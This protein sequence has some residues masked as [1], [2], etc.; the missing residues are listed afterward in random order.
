MA[1]V[2]RPFIFLRFIHLLQRER[3]RGK[4]RERENASRGRGSRRES[5][6]KLPIEL[7]AKLG[8]QSHNP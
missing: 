7:G 2:I 8:A 1:Y 5:S 6:S 3:E 4:E